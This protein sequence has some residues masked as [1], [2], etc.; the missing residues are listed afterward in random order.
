MYGIVY[1]AVNKISNKT[2]VGI[3]TKTLEERI[4]AHIN[5]ANR[6]KSY[7]QTALKKYG[8]DS[9]EFSI[10]DSANT[11]EE[12][13]EKER[14]WIEKLDTLKN[15]YNLTIGGGGITDM[16]KEIRDK[17]SKSK[18]GKPNPKL[19]NRLITEEQR[20]MISRTLGGKPIILTEI[21]TGKIIKLETLRSC[22]RYGVNPK[23]LALVL[24]NKRKTVNGYTAKYDSQANTEG[25]TEGL[26][27][28]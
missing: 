14:Q 19:K 27:H 23:N 6:E 5:K 8:R 25:D 13:F 26:V 18:S 16:T 28:L 21:K 11:K 4:F 17:I 24:K 10:I 22:I 3:T 9:F 12:L 20:V 15:G 7:F 2:Y 1:K